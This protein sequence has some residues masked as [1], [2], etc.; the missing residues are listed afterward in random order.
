MKLDG[1]RESD[2]MDSLNLN[3][4][5]SSIFKSGEG[6][7]K[8]GSFFFFSK[9]QKFVIKTLRR[10]EKKI[11]MDMLDD[12]IDH[13]KESPQSLLVRIYGIYTLKTKIFGTVD[14]ILME[15]T[16]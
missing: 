2:I 6:M 13:I 4:N 10:D 9:D 1:I 12:M 3:D 8:S 15:N 14:L 5:V 16:F 11:L 7:G